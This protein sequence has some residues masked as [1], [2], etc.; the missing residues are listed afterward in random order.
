MHDT[1]NLRPDT[2]ITRGED[3]VFQQIDD[4]LLAVDGQAGVCYS[5]NESAGRVWSLIATPA[6]LAAICAQLRQEYDV[7]EETCLREVTAVVRQLADA[8]LVRVG[9]DGTR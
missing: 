2:L 4:E 6:S 1:N 7:D 5:L 3:V 8:K 9:G